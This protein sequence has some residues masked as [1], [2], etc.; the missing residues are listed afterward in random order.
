MRAGNIL[1]NSEPDLLTESD[2]VMV[3]ILQDLVGK[4][5][6]GVRDTL[7]V[8]FFDALQA[9]D[10]G[11]GD[12]INMLLAERGAGPRPG[13]VASAPEFFF[14]TP[15]R[16]E[17]AATPLLPKRLA[18]DLT[19][20]AAAGASLVAPVSGPDPLVELLQKQTEIL[21]KA[22]EEEGQEEV[23]GHPGQPGSALA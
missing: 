20:Q 21:G 5:D 15:S 9:N 12:V 2:K 8:M 6:K 14:L 3:E 22:F 13:A 18:Q 17:F 19:G 23:L 1:L 10:R 4:D 16:E 11:R 7:K